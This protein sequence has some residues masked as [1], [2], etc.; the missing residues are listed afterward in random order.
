MKGTAAALVPMVL[1]KDGEDEA[2]KIADKLLVWGTVTGLVLGVAQMAAL[3]FLVP[4]FSTL[5]EVQDAVRMPALI[6]AFI[7][8]MNGPGFAGEGILL[9]LGK[10]NT[11]SIITMMGATSMVAGLFS[12]LGMSLN[13]IFLSIGSFSAFSSIS[14]LYHYLKVGPLRKKKAHQK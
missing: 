2:R 1:A 13:G 7:Q 9:G 8:F 12:P 5:P 6:S 10:Y 4:L 3:P 11:L 14:M